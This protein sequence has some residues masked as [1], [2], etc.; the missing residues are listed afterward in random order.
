MT[1]TLI[2]ILT[3]QRTA[4]DV[5]KNKYINKISVLFLSIRCCLKVLLPTAG[6][7]SSLLFNS[8]HQGQQSSYRLGFVAETSFFRLT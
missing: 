8:P 5:L 6:S 3:E 7:E 2:V 1:P 4:G